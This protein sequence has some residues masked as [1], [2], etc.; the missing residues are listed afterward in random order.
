MA[1]EIYNQL[2]ANILTNAANLTNE[3]QV[4]SLCDW[5]LKI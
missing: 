4:V 1:K 3:E 5:L 2:Q